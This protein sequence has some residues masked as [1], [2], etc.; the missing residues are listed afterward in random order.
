[1]KKFLNLILFI[2][3]F[4]FCGVIKVNAINM[5]S[6]SNTV[7]AGD[8]FTINFS[9][10]KIS[11]ATPDYEFSYDNASNL[12]KVGNP[13]G[14]SGFDK[15]S[16]TT[17]TGSITF[18]AKEV[19]SDYTVTFQIKD[20][21]SG[22]VKKVSVAIKTKQ[23][24]VTTKTTTTT[25]TT[26]Q[27]PKSNNANLKTLEIKANDGSDVVLS[28]AFNSGVY[29][30]TATVDATIKTINV[31]ATL[32]DNKSNMVISNNAN[33]ELVAGENN[34]IVITVTAEDGVTKKAYNINIKREAL[35]ADATLKS[36]EIKECKDFKFKEDKFSYNVKVANSVNSLSIDYVL[37]SLDAT[38]SISGNKN[39]KN[40]SKVKIL[41]TAEDGTKKE[42]ILNIVKSLKVTKKNVNNVVPEKNPLIIMALSMIGF[43]LIGGI[44][45]VVKK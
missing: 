22:E 30:Y 10:A 33:E 23:A 9:E 16:F 40:G 5:T 44:I 19:K 27:A 43:G 31:N 1:M 18:K 12:E 8:N 32:E 17:T 11:T 35:T 36:L 13:V 3:I 42:Y 39:L 38:V 29:D 45:Y 7:T 15:L 34:K 21:N 37:S 24:P 41:V 4:C 28:P 2:C 26:T 6:S 20:L 25:T 14:F